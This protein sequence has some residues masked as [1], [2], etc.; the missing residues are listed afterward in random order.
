MMPH[1]TICDSTLI[2]YGCHLNAELEKWN[3]CFTTGNNPQEEFRVPTISL[4][5]EPI[6]KNIQEEYTQN[7]DI[8]LLSNLYSLTCCERF[9]EDNDNRLQWDLLWNLLMGTQPGCKKTT[10]TGT[11]FMSPIKT[12]DWTMSHVSINPQRMLRPGFE[13]E[14]RDWEPL[15][16]DRATPSERTSGYGIVTFIF[17][18]LVFTVAYHQNT[19]TYSSRITRHDTG[20]VLNL[21]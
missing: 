12:E 15:M 2:Q 1:V 20:T 17:S 19:V 4:E 11:L 5:S 3:V 21:S 8:T 7:N 16:L 6:K 18:C 14:S 9:E 13:P 10:I